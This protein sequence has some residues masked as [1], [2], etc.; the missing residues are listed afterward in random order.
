[1][2]S[3]AISIVR[4]KRKRDE[5]P[6]AE[7]VLPAPKR[8]PSLRS[9]SLDD[10]ATTTNPS[11]A[12]TAG[13][14]A[15]G[16]LSTANAKGAPSAPTGRRFRLVGTAHVKDG[17][18]NR[19]AAAVAAAHREQ[20]ARQQSDARRK[21]VAL[22]RVGDVLELQSGAAAAAGGGGGA[23][24]AAAPKLRPFGTPLPPR[25]QQR[26]DAAGPAA[27]WSAPPCANG[28]ADDALIESMWADAA[29]AA[30]MGVDADVTSAEGEADADGDGF[31]YDE[32]Y[33]AEDAE[34]AGD[35]YVP[36]EIWWEEELDDE[37]VRQLE[38]AAGFGGEASDS[39][40]EVDYPDEESGSEDSDQY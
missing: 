39:E 40:G 13:A 34:G 14:V 12:T 37:L 7:F 6:L 3:S 30:A 17:A 33:L 8:Q 11:A 35:G 9:L 16:D 23:R 24:S 27:G 10:D 26:S 20:V 32:Y 2:A 31:V 22:R 19:D 38:A 18:V 28:D 29:A 4:I 15:A 21:L 5:P 25:S 36:P 1:M